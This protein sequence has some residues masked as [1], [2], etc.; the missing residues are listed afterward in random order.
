MIDDSSSLN[1]K[2]HACDGCEAKNYNN[3]NCNAQEEGEKKTCCSCSSAIVVIIVVIFINQ[4]IL[5]LLLGYERECHYLH[6]ATLQ[7][8]DFEDIFA[9]FF[10]YFC[11]ESLIQNDDDASNIPMH[12]CIL[13]SSSRVVCTIKACSL[14]IGFGLISNKLVLTL[15]FEMIFMFSGYD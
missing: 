15:R 13:S 5:Q 11:D 12:V 1:H 8:H 14:I 4:L 10:F 6:I 7:L 3:N 2:S 9:H